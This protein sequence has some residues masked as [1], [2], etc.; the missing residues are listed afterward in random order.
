MQWAGGV[1]LW[2]FRRG[3]NEGQPPGEGVI[4]ADICGAG[5]MSQGLRAL[6]ALPGPQRLAGL[7]TLPRKAPTSQDDPRA[8]MAARSLEVCNQREEA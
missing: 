7:E 6:A 2:S 3:E 5:E 4:K 8:T 1:R